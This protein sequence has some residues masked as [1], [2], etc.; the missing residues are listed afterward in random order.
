[1]SIGNAFHRDQRK[2]IYIKQLHQQKRSKQKLFSIK[3]FCMT[4]FLAFLFVRVNLRQYDHLYLKETLR[5]LSRHRNRNTTDR[6]CPAISY[7]SAHQTPEHK[8]TQE[9]EDYPLF[10]CRVYARKKDRW[11]TNKHRINIHLGLL[12]YTEETRPISTLLKEH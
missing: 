10:C 7:I 12:I 1:M 8:S 11:N 3:L 6:A 5:C 4:L 9:K 2:Y